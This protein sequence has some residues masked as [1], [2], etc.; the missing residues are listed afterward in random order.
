[1][2]ETILDLVKQERARR[3]APPHYVIWVDKPFAMDEAVVEAE[4]EAARR[5]GKIGPHTEIIRVSWEG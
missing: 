4:I 3:A 5:D 2:G 1:M